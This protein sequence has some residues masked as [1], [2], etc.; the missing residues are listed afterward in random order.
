MRPLV[1]VDRESS[2]SCFMS[3]RYVLVFPRKVWVMLTMVFGVV[4]KATE[5]NEMALVE[6]EMIEQIEMLDE[7]WWSGVGQG[8][9]KSGLFPGALLPSIHP[10]S[11]TQH[12]RSYAA[13]GLYELI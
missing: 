12:A 1:L 11:I 2:R 7:G 13:S 3:M 6:G 8:G 4:T 10:F 9:A 5:D